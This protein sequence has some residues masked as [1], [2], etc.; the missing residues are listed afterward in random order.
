MITLQSGQ[1]LYGVA[2]MSSSISYTITGLEVQ[3][4]TESYKV[5]CQGQLSSSIELMY[6]VP[7][8]NSTFIKQIFLSNTTG[9][10]ING[11]KLFIGGNSPSNQIV[12]LSLFPS[13]SAKFDSTGWQ[14]YDFLGIAVKDLSLTTIYDEATSTIAYL[15]NALPGIS[16]S[17]AFWRISKINTTSGVI[18]T[19]ADGN[20]NFDNIWADRL[21]LNYS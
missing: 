11:V 5:L 7:A 20:S 21:S 8:L 12:N 2:E 9:N 18:T 17:S 10:S 14:T 19:W 16:T 3:D 4:G 15:G 1:T 6:T 13:G